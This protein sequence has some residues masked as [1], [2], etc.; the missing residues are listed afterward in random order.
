MYSL[1]EHNNKKLFPK[2]LEESYV[3][4]ALKTNNA[5]VELKESV[6]GQSKK[7]IVQIEAIHV[8]RTANYTYYTKEGLS[9]GINSWTTPYQKPVL[10]HH[11]DHD[12]EP[13]GRILDAT[14]SETTPSGKSGLIFKAEITDPRAI[15]K[16]LDGRYQTVSIG[17][18]TDKVTCNICGTDRTED[19][20]DHYPGQ[21]YEEQTCHFIIGT[22]SGRE[23]SYVNVPADEYAGNISVQLQESKNEETFVELN[24][25]RGR[26]GTN[27]LE[28]EKSHE[29]KE[30]VS[31]LERSNDMS[32]EE[33]NQEQEHIIESSELK[34]NEEET[35]E[36][37]EKIEENNVEEELKSEI[38]SLQQTVEEN[39]KE[40]ESLKE[41]L[42]QKEQ[43]LQEMQTQKE[44]YD[45]VLEENKNLLKEIHKNLC[46]KVV[47]LKYQLQ[48]PEVI[49]KKREEALDTHIMRS[50]DSLENSY[51][52]LMEELKYK[53]PES[54]SVKNP[55]LGNVEEA[56][57]KS[58]ITKKEAEN[59]LKSMFGG[60]RK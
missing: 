27:L 59:L 20:C 6:G 28:N 2:E 58:K 17:A 48:K 11:N 7:L 41:E 52:D 15:E 35:K 45:L 19:W 43:Q 37:T 42:L 49:S 12:G 18:T 53:R 34:E 31:D 47:D 57:Q 22:T 54:G 9:S 30:S 33:K 23:V 60:K 14:F 40:I 55:G 8:G 44:E 50:K 16:V 46:E 39:K 56:E 4:E 38:L 36:S 10:T 3:V 25:Y 24:H 21:N 29:L 5:D 13:I 1:Q 51:N 26:D 32:L